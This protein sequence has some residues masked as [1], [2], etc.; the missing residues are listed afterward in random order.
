MSKKKK[1][2]LWNPSKGTLH[3]IDWMKKQGA[4]Y[5]HIGKTL[6][7]HNTTIRKHLLRF[8]KSK[9]FWSKIKRFFR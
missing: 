4:S 7:L 3:T 1:R 9:S 2:K 5:R 6:G 8:R